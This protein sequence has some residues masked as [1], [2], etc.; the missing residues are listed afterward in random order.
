MKFYILI[1]KSIINIDHRIL[2]VFQLIKNFL[3]HRISISNFIEIWI[4]FH[5]SNYNNICQHEVCIILVQS[6]SVWCR[7]YGVIRTIYLYVKCMRYALKLYAN[8]IHFD[9][10]SIHD[11]SV[12]YYD[13]FLHGWE[14]YKNINWASVHQIP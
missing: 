11:A 5:S 9:I 13:E 14:M 2:C 8:S 3:V 12:H 10:K 6:K 1:N 7:V 4:W